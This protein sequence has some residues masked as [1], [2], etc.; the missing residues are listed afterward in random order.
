[1][2]TLLEV[3]NVKVGKSGLTKR[4]TQWGWLRKEKVDAD[5]LLKLV[6]EVAVEHRHTLGYRAM[7]TILRDRYRLKVSRIVVQLALA[8]LFPEESKRRRHGKLKRRQYNGQGAR[9]ASHID[10]G[11][12]LKYYGFPYWLEID[13]WSRKILSLTVVDSNNDPVITARIWLDTVARYQSVPVLLASDAGGE[14]ILNHAL[15]SFLRRNHGDAL[16]GLLSVMVVTFPKNQVCMSVCVLCVR[17]CA[18]WHACAVCVLVWVCV[19][20][21]SLGYAVLLL[22]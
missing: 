18:G 5:L 12:K 15:Q 10:G 16:A 1:M 9:Y 2:K 3:W 22:I 17:V 21:L 6:D 7:Y 20:V 8:D 19:C 14:N 11:D 4:F 13:G